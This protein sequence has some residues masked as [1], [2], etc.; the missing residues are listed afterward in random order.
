MVIFSELFSAEVQGE[1]VR[2]LK[3]LTKID[4]PSWLV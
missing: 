2:Y 3:G 4:D 1:E